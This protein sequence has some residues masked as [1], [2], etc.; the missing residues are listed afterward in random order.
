[1]TKS[2]TLLLL[3]FTLAPHLKVLLTMA[4][5]P[6]NVSEYGRLWLEHCC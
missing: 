6:V 3:L 4:H 5:G 1:M 2:P